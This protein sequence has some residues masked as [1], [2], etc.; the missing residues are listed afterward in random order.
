MNAE[1]IGLHANS[2]PI[3]DKASTPLLNLDGPPEFIDT[4]G[5]G[6]EVDNSLKKKKRRRRKRKRA[7]MVSGTGD[8]LH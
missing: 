3:P 2:V 5:K 7:K 1:F 8:N 4:S 6:S